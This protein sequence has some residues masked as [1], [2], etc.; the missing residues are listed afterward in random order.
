[1][2]ALQTFTN[3]RAASMMLG[4]GG[5]YLAGNTQ[6]RPNGVRFGRYVLWPDNDRQ[7]FAALQPYANERSVV[8]GGTAPRVACSQ[9]ARVTA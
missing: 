1:V 2:A 9:Y 4:L 8:R 3:D 6:R 5:Q 7:E